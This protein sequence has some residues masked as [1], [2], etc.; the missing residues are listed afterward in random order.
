MRPKSLFINKRVCHFYSFTLKITISYIVWCDC[1][2]QNGR[3]M[4][5]LFS[6]LAKYENHAKGKVE[7]ICVIFKIHAYINKS[8]VMMPLEQ[9]DGYLYISVSCI[10]H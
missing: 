8:N 7:M 2:L 6:Q 5:M 9:R 3:S 10:D 4:S 1:I